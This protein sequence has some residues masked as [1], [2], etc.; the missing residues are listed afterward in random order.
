M[1]SFLNMGWKMLGT[2]MSEQTKPVHPSHWYHRRGSKI[3]IVYLLLDLIPSTLLVLSYILLE[4][5][6]PWG[7]CAN[8]ASSDIVNAYVRFQDKPK[9]NEK[10]EDAKYFCD[11]LIMAKNMTFSLA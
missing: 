3:L 8:A 10:R 4:L 11:D 7:I 9:K 6:L 1:E 2:V 5:A